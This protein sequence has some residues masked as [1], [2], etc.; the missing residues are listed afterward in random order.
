MKNLKNTFGVLILMVF[1]VTTSSC[2]QNKIFRSITG[3]RGGP[4]GTGS[5]GSGTTTSPNL[6]NI[7]AS[8]NVVPLTLGVG[9]A[10]QISVSVTI[11]VP[12]TT[13][14]Q[15]VNNLLLDTGS[16]GVRIFASALGNVYQGL[17]KTGLANCTSYAD[18]SYDWGPVVS[19]DVVLGQEKATAVPIQ[20]IDNAYADGAQACVASVATTNNAVGVTAPPYPDLQSSE[21]NGIVGL[22][23]LSQDCGTLCTMDPAN[24]VYFMCTGTSCVGSVAS[25]V[26]QM[27][28]PVSKLPND[29]NGISISFPSITG[30]GA[31][32]GSGVL[33]IGIATQSN[34]VPSSG[35]KTLT[36]NSNE[37]DKNFGY[38]T[39]SFVGNVITG[40]IDSGSGC[41]AFPFA[42]QNLLPEDH[43]GSYM[44]SVPVSLSATQIGNN[45]VQNP[46]DFTVAAWNNF[47][48][49]PK[50]ADSLGSAAS[51]ASSNFA[52]GFPFFIGRTVYVGVEGKSSPLGTGLYWAY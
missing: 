29:N 27:T 23:F 6:V 26:E 37:T 17:I 34:N 35:V 41:L 10:N 45:N 20:I 44:P 3:L 42:D 8:A 14:C 43:N 31:N 47:P 13:N 16:T 1:T 19:A 30:E 48:V 28:N 32:S 11:C 36:A 50:C 46:V 51:F 24:G 2:T 5:S 21:Y 33:T 25:L 7:A 12:N 4:T 49:Q 40:F 38:F 9:T 52:W 39:T 15:V 18:N 22:N